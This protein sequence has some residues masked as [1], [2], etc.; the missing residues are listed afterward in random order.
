MKNLKSRRAAGAVVLLISLLVG[1]IPTTALGSSNNENH[2]D[3]FYD[4]I[5]GY[6]IIAAQGKVIFPVVGPFGSYLE[7][8]LSNKADAERYCYHEL[9]DSTLTVAR[10]FQD[11]NKFI[12]TGEYQAS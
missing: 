3:G 10:H 1:M 9:Y 7:S 11:K 12:L 4:F 8:Q 6:T 5:E 2:P